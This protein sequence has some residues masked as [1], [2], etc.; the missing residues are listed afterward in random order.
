M[1]VM[2]CVVVLLSSTA[3]PP[4]PKASGAVPL[5]MESSVTFVIATLKS[6]EEGT[7]HNLLLLLLMEEIRRLQQR[8]EIRPCT[9][10]SG[11]VCR[12]VPPPH[13][14]QN[15]S[16]TGMLRV[17]KNNNDGNKK[18][19]R[20]MLLLLPEEEARG[21]LATNFV[22]A[23]I[24]FRFLTGSLMT[25]CLSELEQEPPEDPSRSNDILRRGSVLGISRGRMPDAASEAGKVES[26]ML[27]VFGSC[28]SSCAPFA[29]ITEPICAFALLFLSK[30]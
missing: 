14:I 28:L 18:N 27:R 17:P 24:H 12:I 4:R 10:A 6:K 22:S 21:M 7:F 9:V 30:E 11:G 29:R 16:T 5:R 26:T 19:K 8:R 20:P 13:E 25:A 23:L 15:D 2:P 1:V 3:S